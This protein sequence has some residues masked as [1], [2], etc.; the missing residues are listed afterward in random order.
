MRK[1]L[2]LL[3]ASVV[4]VLGG[5]PVESQEV[6]S[7]GR[8]AYRAFVRIAC[9][10]LERFAG[11][12]AP[13]DLRFL[14]DGGGGDGGGSSGGDDGGTGDGAGGSSDS[15]GSGASDATAGDTSTATADDAATAPASVAA[16]TTDNS[17]PDA[18]PTTVAPTDPTAPTDE[19][20]AVT[21]E[22]SAIEDEAVR[23]TR[24]AMI[25]VALLT[26]LPV[27][28]Q[29][30][31]PPA[32]RPVRVVQFLREQ[33]PNRWTWRLMQLI[34]SAARSKYRRSTDLVGDRTAHRRSCR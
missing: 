7:L 22:L 34:V 1:G 27:C 28:L 29:R 24:G 2:L 13:S 19:Q 25:Q 20:T 15:D 31:Q 30:D 12:L 18:D 32:Y 26:R 11:L 14:A 8:Y 33:S 17:D 5:Q 21:P 10:D 16:A 3:A 4:F 6:S 23:P 9:G